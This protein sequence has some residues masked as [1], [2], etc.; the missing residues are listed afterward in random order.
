MS[1][2]IEMIVVL[3]C[4]IAWALA[5]VRFRRAASLEI[6]VPERRAPSMP[7]RSR[8]F[9]DIARIS[10]EGAFRPT[11][12]RPTAAPDSV[13]AAPVA[14]PEL[15]SFSLK[16]VVG[17]PWFA[18]LSP[19]GQTGGDRVFRAGDSI[20]IVEVRSVRSDGV[21]LRVGDTTWTIALLQERSP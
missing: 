5:V 15:P 12:A 20:G 19:R 11:T 18:V 13:P 3:L 16:A 7:P 8:V 4:A 1:R 21:T 2:R 17:P 9:H 10:R 14:R 6:R